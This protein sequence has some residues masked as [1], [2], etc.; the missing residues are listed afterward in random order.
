MLDKSAMVLSF[1]IEL[2]VIVEQV[3]VLRDGA[4]L[5]QVMARMQV[6][7]TTPLRWRYRFLAGITETD[8]TFFLHSNNILADE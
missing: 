8:E 3:A 7:Q 6:A 5:T 4:M 2:E 1:E